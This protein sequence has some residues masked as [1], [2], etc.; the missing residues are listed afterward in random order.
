MPFPILTSLIVLPIAGAIVLLFVRGDEPHEGL[1]R[2][3]ALTVSVLVFL[4]TLLLWAL[5]EPGSADFQF[6]VMA[7]WVPG[8]DL[9]YLVCI[10]GI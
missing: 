4:E 6:V 1:V 10:D 3:V 7:V 8:L 2:A 5:F 9:A